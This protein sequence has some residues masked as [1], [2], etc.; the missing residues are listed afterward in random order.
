MDSNITDLLEWSSQTYA[1]VL[2]LSQAL[3]QPGDT[4]PQPWSWQV[5]CG[6]CLHPV[7]PPGLSWETELGHN[8][9]RVVLKQAL[10]PPHGFWP[11]H[12]TSHP[13]RG[14]LLGKGNIP[15]CA[16]GSL[17]MSFSMCLLSP[18]Q[19]SEKTTQERDRS[20]CGVVGGGGSCSSVGGA[21]AGERS[22]DR[23]RTS[24]SQRLLST[25][26]HHHHL[27]YSLLPAQ[28]N[29]PYATG[30]S[31]AGLGWGGAVPTLGPWDPH[32]VPK[33]PSPVY[34]LLTP[35]LP[36][37]SL[38]HSHRCQPARLCSLPVPTAPEVRTV[39]LCSCRTSAWAAGL[40][41][42]GMPSRV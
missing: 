8:E 10:C 24:P 27:G 28:Y 9:E 1:P 11:S 22:S 20:G 13:Q 42:H 40:G 6:G 14:N 16:L 33:A 26:H 32:T 5:G 39:R 3:Q 25:H 38:L 15:V 23:P 41:A 12:P 36:C 17:L 31:G 35:L 21:G 4:C 18:L 29:L 30:E 37:R 7:A 2:G 19:I 34:Q